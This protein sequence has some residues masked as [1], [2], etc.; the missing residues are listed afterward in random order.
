MFPQIIE[1]RMPI[2]GQVMRHGSDD[3][4]RVRFFTG[5]KFLGELSRIEGRDMYDQD[6][7]LEYIEIKV[8]GGDTVVRV[9]TSDDIKRFSEKYRQWKL[10][11]G[12]DVGTPLDALGFTDTQ[13]DM[14]TRANIHSVEQLAA[15]GDQALASIGLGAINMR[16]RAQRHI[17]AQPVVNEEVEALKAQ[18]AT[19]TEKLSQ[20]T[21]MVEGLL[22]KK[23]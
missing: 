1:D 20:L 8:P 16:A 9:A 7:I 22:L 23:K 19:L 6:R 5:P 18:N 12:G 17:Q 10:N 11:E 14:C 15:I 2:S 3:A 21:E 13:K 4:L